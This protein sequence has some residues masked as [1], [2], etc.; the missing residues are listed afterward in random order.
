MTSLDG[1]GRKK[2]MSKVSKKDEI[3]DE[4]EVKVEAPK[5]EVVASKPVEET[6]NCEECQGD[7]KWDGV[8]CEA[9]KGS[10]KIF[11]DGT[12]IAHGSGTFIAKG[13]KYEEVKL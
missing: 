2:K 5:E 9:C 4:E 7:G 11:K 13:G 6:K 12:V 1:G 10:G 3:M 8:E